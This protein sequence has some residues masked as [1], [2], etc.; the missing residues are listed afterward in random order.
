MLTVFLKR[1]RETILRKQIGSNLYSDVRIPVY[2]AGLAEYL[3]AKK[4][5]A[6]QLS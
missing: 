4:F 1:T 2:K 6:E 3:P 5:L